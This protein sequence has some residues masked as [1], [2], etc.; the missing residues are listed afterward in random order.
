MFFFYLNA[1][2]RQKWV[3]ESSVHCSILTCEVLYGHRW[4]INHF[5]DFTCSC[6]QN[7]KALPWDIK[8][9]GLWSLKTFVIKVRIG[10]VEYMTVWGVNFSS[11]LFSVSSLLY[12][13]EDFPSMIIIS[14]LFISTFIYLVYFKVGEK[15]KIFVGLK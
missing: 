8:P 6:C 14:L 5:V 11:I 2:L 12:H 4:M 10:Y 7:C 1:N 3:A 15:L 13:I 9:N